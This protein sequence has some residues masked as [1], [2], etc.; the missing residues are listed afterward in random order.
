MRRKLLIAGGALAAAAL[1]ATLAAGAFV[2]GW[3]AGQLASMEQTIEDQQG[4]D[5]DLGGIEVTWWSSFPQITA[6]V[7]D[8]AVTNRAP[9]AGIE[10][11][12]AAE[13]S[14]QLE[15][16]ALLA[17][18]I[19]VQK[20]TLRDGAVHLVARGEQANWSLGGEAES[21]D[22][23]S[24]TTPVDLQLIEIEGLDI[25]YG[26]RPDGLYAQVDDLNLRT[27]GTVDAASVRFA[28]T[29][30]VAGISAGDPEGAWLT[31]VPVKL[32]LPLDYATTTGGITLGEVKGRIADLPVELA[33]TAVPQ[34]DAW[35]LDLTLGTPGAELASLLS[36]VPHTD[37]DAL[38]SVEASGTLALS[39][40]VKGRYEGETY[41]GAQVDLTLTEARIQAPGG[42]GALTD[43]NVDLHVH[44]E[45]GPADDTTLELRKARWTHLGQ[46]MTLSATVT[47]PLS[48]PSLEATADGR[49]DVGALDRTLP[50]DIGWTG[51]VALDAS[52]STKG[53]TVRR[54]RG[55]VR[56]KQL[57]SEDLQL[58]VVDLSLDGK[59]VSVRQLDVR[60]GKMVASI[61]G[62]LRDAIGY[63]MGE[64]PLGGDLVVKAT[65]L[66]LR[67]D[68]PEPDPASEEPAEVTTVPTDLALGITLDIGKVL[69]ED[70]VLERLAGRVDIAEGAVALQGLGF[71]TLGGEVAVDGVYRAPT[72]TDASLDGKLRFSELKVDQVMK[73]VDT[74]AEVVPAAAGAG[75]KVG[76]T[77]QVDTKIGADGGPDLPTLFSEGLVLTVGSS[78]RPDAL[79]AAAKKLGVPALASLDLSGTTF[80]YRIE[81]GRLH[82][83]PAK[84]KLGRT[85][86]T[87]GGSAGVVDQTLDLFMDFTLPASQLAGA[88]LDSVLPKGV[89]DV[90]VRIGLVGPYAKP[91]LKITAGGLD[92]VKDDLVDKGKEVAGDLLAEASAQGDKLIAEA[93]K[94]AAALVAE[95]EK[96]AK[97]LTKEA[98]KQGD[99]L[100]KAANNPIAKAAAEKAKDE[101]VKQAGKQGDKL[102][103]EAD[104]QGDKLIAAAEKQKE[105]L[106][107]DAQNKLK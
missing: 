56:A 97:T 58:P 19:T 93:K 81:K 37:A 25:R 70:Y 84:V 95:A 3:V 90:D 26:S 28:S 31:S 9:F 12:R 100:V 32:T 65:T 92:G 64:A 69:Y 20:I 36:L 98:K 6:T 11:F 16:S 35:D 66:D 54:A 14:V 55:T 94:A 34:G 29:L 91:R 8:V 77:V 82:L 46:P 4:V 61:S 52:V 1:V 33:G 96:G 79:E 21:S 67:S 101:L 17:D 76:G 68:E 42:P 10:L 24:S 45:T 47:P 62:E 103:K 104:K 13:V 15:L 48:N 88:K 40:A 106:V 27:S 86:A 57:A 5:L 78:V 102:V 2:P 63:G 22:A 23:E 85:P 107:A 18:E 43:L 53:S 73:T 7:S 41:P 87:L 51:V 60:Q 39:A 89:P 30:S 49:V 72:P 75:G 83:T 105:K 50:T 74:A 38:A 71:Q 99:K 59:T 44:R 80:D